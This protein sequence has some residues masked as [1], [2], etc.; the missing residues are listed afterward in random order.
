MDN[1][2][3]VDNEAS[4]KLLIKTTEKSG[5]INLSSI[6]GS[7]NY[8]CNIELKDDEI[9]EFSCPSCKSVITLNDSCPTCQ[10]PMSTVILDIGEK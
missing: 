2:H 10:A 6:Y 8:V 9:A 5:V 1:E 7:Y 3:K 4:I